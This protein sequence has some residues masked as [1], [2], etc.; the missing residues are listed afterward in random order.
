VADLHHLPFAD[1]YLRFQSVPFF[2]CYQKPLTVEQ[3][4]SF[5]EINKSDA[6]YYLHDLCDKK[7]INAPPPYFSGT[8][9]WHINQNGRKYIMCKKAKENKP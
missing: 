9:Q 1:F 8:D 2:A 4:C 3:V 6:S 7:L 5:L